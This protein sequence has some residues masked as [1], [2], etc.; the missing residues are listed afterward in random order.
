MSFTCGEKMRLAAPF[1]LAIFTIMALATATTGWGRP[2]Q[3]PVKA[4]A[5]THAPTT[6][7]PIS[8]GPTAAQHALDS[9]YMRLLERTNAQLSLWWS[10]YGVMVGALGALFA[11]L[12]IVATIVIFRQSSEYR[13]LITRSIAEYQ[14][15]L[16]A[17]IKDKNQEIQLMNTQVTANIERATMALA[18]A[19]G[20]QKAEIEKQIA[21]LK[22]FKETLKAREQPKFFPSETGFSALGFTPSPIEQAFFEVSEKPKVQAI[23]ERLARERAGLLGSLLGS[24]EPKPPE[25]DK[26]PPKPPPKPTHKPKGE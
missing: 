4:T 9:V 20:A 13:A 19:T 26:P 14:G 22:E 5:R 21:E 10:P 7:A 6:T 16:N 3:T 8:P 15:I 11:V 25:P 12:A 24:Q 18:T 1:G 17:F 2:V 23:M